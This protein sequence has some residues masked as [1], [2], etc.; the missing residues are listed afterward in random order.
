[1]AMRRNPAADVIPVT[2][3]PPVMRRTDALDFLRALRSE[4]VATRAGRAIAARKSEICDAVRGAARRL[5]AAARA[6][7]FETVYDEAH[8]IRGLAQTGGLAASGHIADRLCL[9][10]DAVV[11]AHQPVDSGIVGLHV[12]A[13]ARAAHATDEATMLGSEVAEQLGTLVARK[14]G[15]AAPTR[16]R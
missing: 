10:L 3:Y 5:E 12:G 11:R 8:E 7:H 6:G 2:E 15:P 14:L 1:M 9:Y 4:E 13:I 16:F